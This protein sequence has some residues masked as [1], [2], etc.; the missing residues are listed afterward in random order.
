MD[1]LRARAP[2]NCQARDMELVLST[3]I[4]DGRSAPPKIEAVYFW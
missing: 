3:E 1:T 4:I 2:R